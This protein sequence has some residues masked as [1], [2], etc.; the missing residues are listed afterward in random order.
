M[1]TEAESE[2]LEALW[3][4]GPLSFADLIAAVRARR[5]WGEATVKT[6]LHRAIQK[7]AVR[8]E[9]RDGRTS[10]HAS[11]DRQAW[12]DA[13]IQALA[14]RLFGGDLAALARHLDAAGRDGT[15]SLR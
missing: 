3:R 13:E 9:R 6:L 10:Y 1:I 5:P 2:V 4:E 12:L 8:S 15:P 7:G 11:L 14:D